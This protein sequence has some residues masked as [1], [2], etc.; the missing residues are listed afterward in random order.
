[1]FQFVQATSMLCD[2]AI[3]NMSESL[4]NKYKVG[5]DEY[6]FRLSS[7]A[8]MAITLAAA[9]KGD[10]TEGVKFMMMAGTNEEIESGIG[11]NSMWTAWKKMF[12]LV[13]FCTVGFFGSSC[14]A[15]ITREYGALT[16]SVT[17]TARK[18]TTLFMSFVLFKNVFTWEHGL[19]IIIFMS[20]LMLKSFSPSKGQ[21]K[22]IGMV[23]TN[24][25]MELKSS[26]V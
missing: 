17:S 20:P 10:I 1:M 16:M 13:L 5:H 7:V 8:T 21:R 15:C 6:L 4:M 14:A 23:S 19:G 12:A 25:N 18:A 9:Y 26:F 24:A 22:A 2:G 3:V 11:V